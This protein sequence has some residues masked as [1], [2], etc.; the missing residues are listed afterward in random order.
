MNAEQTDAASIRI[1]ETAGLKTSS[2]S[3]TTNRWISGTKI[4]ALIIV[5]LCALRERFASA[6]TRDLK[7]KSQS[8]STV[9]P[10]DS[11]VASGPMLPVTPALRLQESLPRGRRVAL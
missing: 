1:K 9:R 10:K 6:Q 2:R 5:G 3:N 8:S 11:S 7:V 4:L